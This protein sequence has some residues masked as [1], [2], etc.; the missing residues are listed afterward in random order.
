MGAPRLV[1]LSLIAAGILD[2]RRRP[3]I[4]AQWLS[5]SLRLAGL[6][7]VLFVIAAGIGCNNTTYGPNIT[8]SS[9]G[10]PTGTYT[11]SIRG[12]LG[13]NNSVSRGTTINLSV[14]PG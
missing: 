11:I 8:Q 10:T 3:G 14:G 2:R 13:N 1:A 4:G 5:L 7:A 9:T 12:I 6:G